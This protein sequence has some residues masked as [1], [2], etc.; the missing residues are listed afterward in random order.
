M[1][2][3]AAEEDVL[4]Q[5]KL[6]DTPLDRAAVVGIGH[7]FGQQQDC[8]RAALPHQRHRLDN[9]INPIERAQD[10]WAEDDPPLRHD[11]QKLPQR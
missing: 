7:V 11:A 5:A 10:L 6:I 3:L 2:D 4:G 8:V 9:E 1:I